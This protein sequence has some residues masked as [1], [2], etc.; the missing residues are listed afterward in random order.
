MASIFQN[1]PASP[2]QSPFRRMPASAR[3]SGSGTLEFF[4][5]TL[6]HH[7]LLIAMGLILVCTVVIK[8]HRPAKVMA[9]GLILMQVPSANN[10]TPVI[11]AEMLSGGTQSDPIRDGHLMYLR[12]YEFMRDAATVM[13]A[14][15]QYKT[16]VR[17]LTGSPRYEVT[18]GFRWPWTKIPKREPVAILADRMRPLLA[19]DANAE[20]NIQLEV[21]AHSRKFSLRLAE[22]VIGIAVKQIQASRLENI[23]ASRRNVGDQIFGLQGEL[24]AINEKMIDFKREH[25][26]L[27]T[28][29]LPDDLRNSLSTLQKTLLDAQ[30]QLKEKRYLISK[31]RVEEEEGRARILHTQGVGY[32][33]QVL[34]GRLR[35]LEEERDALEAKVS[36][37]KQTF[38]HEQEKYHFVAEGEEE[39][40]RYKAQNTVKY[41]QINLLEQRRNQ[42]D[43]MVHQI[44]QG[45]RANGP[46]YILEPQGTLRLR[47]KLALFSFIYFFMVGMALHYL[48]ELAPVLHSRDPAMTP[49][50]TDVLPWF[51][52][53]WRQWPARTEKSP[54][55]CGKARELCARGL[56]QKMGRP[57][58]YQV[59]SARSG[60][61]KS[62]L[63]SLLAQQLA[64][65]NK[66]VVVVALDE[67]GIYPDM[68]ANVEV[69]REASLLK[70]FLDDPNATRTALG[71][72]AWI[73]VDAGSLQKHPGH[74]LV[75]PAMD[76]IIMVAAHMQTRR[77]VFMEWQ[78]KIEHIAGKKTI[79]VLN[80]T[81][82][83]GDLP[84]LLSGNSDSTMTMRKAS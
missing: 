49:P 77:G 5:Q 74:L 19:F 28:Q 13:L 33:D 44:T 23:E 54:S 62:Y 36:G 55:V 69:V 12:S 78:E 35:D 8:T 46:A 79:F 43:S 16:L 48:Y 24:D 71:N 47:L 17:I 11:S 41:Q 80:K 22:A 56:L 37:L 51:G 61:G 59:I 14:D 10:A 9:R 39:L 21:Q 83:G 45:I 31:L 64:Y 82:L 63:T 27:S 66:K 70:Q 29:T 50:Q 30:A 3:S 7:K 68:P 25:N 34:E 32:H 52:S 81:D 84:Y 20:S 26:L 73:L 60:E 6:I 53:S 1:R 75:S 65:Q 42:L 58:M 4:L 40:S 38:Q 67:K 2:G 72:P 15:P 18:T 57:G 76:G